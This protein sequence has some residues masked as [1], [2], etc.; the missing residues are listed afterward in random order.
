MTTPS[1][2]A[3]ALLRRPRVWG[4]GGDLTKSDTF[5]ATP[6]LRKWGWRSA[7]HI[8][9]AHYRRSRACEDGGALLA[10]SLYVARKPRG[11]RPGPARA[12][13]PAAFDKAL[14][15]QAIDPGS[16]GVSPSTCGRA[17]EALRR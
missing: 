9:G 10:R 17:G 3:D 12:A 1:S 11:S 4:D 5:L 8:Y 6:S 15:G 13:E 16:L 7:A 2:Q 14:A